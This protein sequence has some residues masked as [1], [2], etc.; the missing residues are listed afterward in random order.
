MPI[1]ARLMMHRPTGA[2]VYAPPCDITNATAVSTIKVQHTASMLR[3][4]QTGATIS[5]TTSRQRRS[6][7]CAIRRQKPRARHCSN[8]GGYLNQTYRRLKGYRPEVALHV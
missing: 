8:R 6:H 7:G 5:T 3:C 4:E 2:G 1:A